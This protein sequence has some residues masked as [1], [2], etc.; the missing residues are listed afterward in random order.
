MKVVA[1]FCAHVVLGAFCAAGPADS[2]PVHAT[3][4]APAPG[5]P[6]V[7]RSVSLLPAPKPAT[8]WDEL[9]RRNPGLGERVEAMKR[10]HPDVKDWDRLMRRDGRPPGVETLFLQFPA[11]RDFIKPEPPAVQTP[12]AQRGADPPG[13]DAGPGAPSAQPHSPSQNPLLRPPDRSLFQHENPLLTPDTP[14]HLGLVQPFRIVPK[15]AR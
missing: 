3:G 14:V 11:L 7:S 9:Y 13:D 10:A 12:F 6:Y 8:S 2:R 1:V 5:L 15:A 4:A